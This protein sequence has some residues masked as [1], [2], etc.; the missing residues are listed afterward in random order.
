MNFDVLNSALL[1]MAKGP[2][3]LIRAL[4]FSAEQNLNDPEEFAVDALFEH[5]QNA[6][7]LIVVEK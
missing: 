2:R 7:L 6:I 5:L 4:Q 3:P 1:G